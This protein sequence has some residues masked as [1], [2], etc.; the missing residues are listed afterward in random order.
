VHTEP[1]VVAQRKLGAGEIIWCGVGPASFRDPRQVAKTL[2]LVALL[3]RSGSARP[4]LAAARSTVDKPGSPLVGPS[5]GFN[6]YR[7]RR[8]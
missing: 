1:A 3:L 6:P 2:R 4:D 8:W 5:L 7:Y